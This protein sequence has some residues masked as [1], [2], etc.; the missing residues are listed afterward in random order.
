[1]RIE[2]PRTFFTVSE[3]IRFFVQAESDGSEADLLWVNDGKFH[4]QIVATVDGRKATIELGG[5]SDGIFN[6]FP[7]QRDVGLARID[8]LGRGKHVLQF[9]VQGDPGTYKNLRGE[10]FRKLN[11]TLVSNVVEFEV[12]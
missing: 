8:N 9:S 4:S 6:E 10:G 12:R 2:T 11:G 3:K 1:M 7:F 5:V